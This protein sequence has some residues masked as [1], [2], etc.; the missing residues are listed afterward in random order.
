MVS[1][2]LIILMLIYFPTSEEKIIKALFCTPLLISPIVFEYYRLVCFK[3]GKIE[4]LVNS[5]A[6]KNQ[7]NL[8]HKTNRQ[9][10]IRVFPAHSADLCGT[11]LCLFDFRLLGGRDGEVCSGTGVY[12]FMHSYFLR[13]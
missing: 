12:L 13:R 11:G 8:R 3:N 2:P 9:Q 6:A 7:Q 10:Q 1:V 4:Y 5:N